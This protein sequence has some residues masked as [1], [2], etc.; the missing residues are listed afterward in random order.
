MSAGVERK[1]GASKGGTAMPIA[2]LVAA[3]VS[4]QYGATLAKGLFASVDAEGTTALRLVFAALVLC[5][6][7]RP[8]RVRP[9]RANLPALVG[10]GVMLA[11]MNLLFYFSL[12]TTPL[13]IA[14]ALQFVGPLMLATLSSRRPIDFAWI[15]LAA[16]GIVLLTP[17]AAVDGGLDGTGVVLA[18]AAGGCWA[19]Y[20]VLGQKAGAELGSRTTAYG[21]VIAA[22]L[23]LPVG[24]A[25]AGPALLDPAILAMGL[26][27]GI[28]SGAIPF[29]LEM[30]A[31]TRLPARTYGVLTSMEP[32]VGAILGF[33]LLGEAL[34]ALQWAGIGL[35]VCAVV[36]TSLVRRT[37]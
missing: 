6:I 9:S 20:I 14:S 11:G 13:G 22:L 18:L 1:G 27:V 16:I 37:S 24:A 29:S 10:Y 4:I 35:I 21:M 15:G 33:L 28:F 17:F 2:S 12:R 7:L 32:V 30:T 3:M 23:V 19:L 34:G 36:G 5:L 26:V 31:L 8:W 25:H